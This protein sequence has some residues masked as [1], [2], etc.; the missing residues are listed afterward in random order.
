M[1]KR[2]AKWREETLVIIIAR[3]VPN[4]D[5]I[6]LTRQIQRNQQRQ[7]KGFGHQC[8]K[9]LFLAR[10]PAQKI[11]NAPE[12][13]M[14]PGRCEKQERVF[15]WIFAEIFGQLHHAHNPTRHLCTRCARGHHRHRI[16]IRVD[17]HVFFAQHGIGSANPTQNIPRLF[18]LPIHSRLQ[19]NIELAL[20]G[21]QCFELFAALLIDPKTLNTIGHL[22]KF[23]LCLCGKRGIG[24]DKHNLLRAEHG[25][26][27]PVVPRIKFHQHHGTI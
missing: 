15:G 17:H 24:F 8:G 11:A 2:L 5:F 18:L 3:A 27:E 25:G 23:G 20:F 21:E 22:Q 14:V 4:P 12:A 19:R 6:C 13:Q 26:I 7:I 10:M 1:H 9:M 16:V